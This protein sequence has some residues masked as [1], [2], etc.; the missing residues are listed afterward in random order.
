MM[1]HGHHFPFER[2]ARLFEKGD[3][4]CVIINLL[5]DKPSH[6]YEIMRAL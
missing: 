3:L 4:K 1:F 2:H 6:G 5:K